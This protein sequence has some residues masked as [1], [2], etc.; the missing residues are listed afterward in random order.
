[1]P[2]PAQLTDDV[3]AIVFPAERKFWPETLG[4]RRRFRTAPMPP[5]GVVN[6]MNMPAGEY[7]VAVANAT[8]VQDWQDPARLDVLS[9]RAQRVTLTDGGRQAVE[10]RR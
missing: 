8:D 6:L 5:K 10:V 9:R 7:F 1:M 3:V 2:P 4:A